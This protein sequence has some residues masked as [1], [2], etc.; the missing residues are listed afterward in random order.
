M[1][2]YLFSQN[3]DML[4]TSFASF[5]KELIKKEIIELLRK[6]PNDVIEHCKDYNKSDIKKYLG[7]NILNLYMIN[8]KNNKASLV[9]NRNGNEYF[10]KIEQ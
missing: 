7:F 8:P 3:Q 2:H 10:R 9:V 6:N 5:N 4:V 1:A